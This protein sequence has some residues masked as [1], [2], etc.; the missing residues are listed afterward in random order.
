MFEDNFG[1][2]ISRKDLLFKKIKEY[3]SRIK[4]NLLIISPYIKTSVLSDLLSNSRAKP[5]TIM[6]TWKLR[7]LQLGS[8]DLELY[9]YCKKRGIFLYLN[10]RVHLKAFIDNYKECIFGSANISKSGLALREDYNYELMKKI[11]KLDSRTILYFKKILNESI[12]VNQDIYEEYKKELGKLKPA[13][14]IKEIEIEKIESK[15]DFLISSL[16]MSYHIKELFHLYSKNFKSKFKEKKECAIHDVALYNIPFGLKEKEFNLFLSKSFFK[17]KFIIKFLKILD[18]N[19]LYFG[20]VKEWIQNNC[21]DVPVPSRRS[22]TGN[23]Q[24]LYRWITEL[25]N[26]KYKIDVPYRYSQRIYKT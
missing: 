4:E 14:K 26:G 20:R 8:S 16:P 1:S 3:V 9:N 23:I 17:A 21:T 19:G 2:Q 25:S 5:I 15:K 24:V 22:L 10:N 18:E 7:D 6:T 11:E 13:E 12:L